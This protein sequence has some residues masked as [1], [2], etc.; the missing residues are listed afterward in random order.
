MAR[1][2][3]G[4]GGGWRE[5]E[6][7]SDPTREERVTD[8][9]ASGR[10]ERGSGTVRQ[11]DSGAVMDGG[12]GETDDIVCLRPRCRSGAPPLSPR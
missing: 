2:P 3:P 6:P 4:G 8:V 1:L 12:G 7:A 9:E 11:D 10:Q 5:A